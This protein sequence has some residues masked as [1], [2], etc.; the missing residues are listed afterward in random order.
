MGDLSEMG[1]LSQFLTETFVCIYLLCFT[2]KKF[3]CRL[4]KF[5]PAIIKNQYQELGIRNQCCIPAGF[6]HM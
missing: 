4:T 2:L 6:P 1:D 3:F 5:L